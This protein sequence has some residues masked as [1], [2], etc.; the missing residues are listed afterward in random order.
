MFNLHT[1]ESNWIFDPEYFDFL[2]GGATYEEQL[3]LL[4]AKVRKA[5]EQNQFTVEDR[6]NSVFYKTYI[7]P[8]LQDNSPIHDMATMIGKKFRRRF[9]VPFSVFKE[10]CSGIRGYHVIPEH[11]YDAKGS[12]T[13]KLPLLVLGALRFWEADAPLTH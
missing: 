2:Y 3:V 8:S 5:R 12:E 6:Y 13:V 10:I 11:G 4:P 1:L 9:R 7:L